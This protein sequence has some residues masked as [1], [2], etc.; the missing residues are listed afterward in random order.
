MGR[1][2]PAAGTPGGARLRAIRRAAGR[3]QLWV[4]AEADLGT[5][6]LQ[7]VESGRVAQPERGTLERILNALDARYSERRDVLELFGYAVS[8][9]PP[10]EADVAW[11][12]EV[13]RHELHDVP[14]PAFVLDC[15][16]KLLA[17]NPIAP[18]LFG[19][20]PDD[21]TFGR[22]A[23]R[24]YLVAWFDPASPIPARVAE[25]DVLLPAVIRAFQY[26]MRQF[27]HEPWYEGILDE[28]FALPRFRHYWDVVEQSPPPVSAARALVPLRLNVPGAGTLQFRLSSEPFVRDARFRIVFYVPGDLAT[29]QWCAG[30][31]TRDSGFGIRG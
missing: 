12:R 23:G 1:R 17:W 20:V 16:H 9:P 11:A 25:P 27:G 6:Y 22:I 28:L 7:R 30:V 5:G 2:V 29:M 4:E 14:F 3:T 21:S 15:T 26:E 24:S 18:R 10:D 19:L 13:S 31:G 8:T